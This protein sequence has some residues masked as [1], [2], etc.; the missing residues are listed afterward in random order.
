MVGPVYGHGVEHKNHFNEIITNA[1]AIKELKGPVYDVAH[2]SHFQDIV[3]SVERAE[4]LIGPV[5]VDEKHSY[6]ETLR[7]IDQAKILTGPVYKIDRF[8]KAEHFTLS[9]SFT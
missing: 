2:S 1:Q 6:S 8:D 9:E 4:K 3:Q 7:P 5:Y